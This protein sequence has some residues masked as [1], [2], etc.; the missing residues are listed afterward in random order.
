M[1]CS[2]QSGADYVS[3]IF[4][5]KAFS[6]LLSFS[7]ECH[8]CLHKNETC[9][10]FSLFSERACS[11]L[12]I[13]HNW[14]FW[15][16]KLILEP[17]PC[18]TLLFDMILAVLVCIH[19]CVQARV[20]ATIGVTRGL[21]DH[22]LKVY[23]SNIYIKPFLSCVPEVSLNFTSYLSATPEE[24]P[25]CLCFRCFSQFKIRSNRSRSLSFPFLRH[26]RKEFLVWP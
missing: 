5:F 19:A 14:I 25:P 8:V 26:I 23:N 15:E 10:V 6:F 18:H 3:L 16:H 1:I 9:S 17:K 7:S 11:L 12:I 4:N 2:H 22:D 21:G 20:M 24:P 13:L